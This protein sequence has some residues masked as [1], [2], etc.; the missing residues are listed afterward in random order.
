MKCS[1]CGNDLAEG[2]NVCSVCGL[3]NET[4]SPNVLKLDNSI[5]T[6]I[7]IEQPVNNVSAPAPVEIQQPINNSLP[8]QPIPIQ[9]P[10]TPIQQNTI[11]N[12][13]NAIQAFPQAFNPTTS[14]DNDIID[15]TQVQPTIVTPTPVVTPMPQPVISPTVVAPPQ[16]QMVNSQPTEVGVSKKKSN[17][18]LLLLTIVLGIIALIIVVL[19]IMK[20]FNIG[21]IA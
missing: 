5:A 9:T 13:Q 17:K 7:P 2:V 11:S 20:I 14:D 15:E 16:P 6:P 19:V 4:N 8:V 1:Q 10:V 3:N 21:Q 18:G 12:N